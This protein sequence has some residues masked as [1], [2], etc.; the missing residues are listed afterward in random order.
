MVDLRSSEVAP[1]YRQKLRAVEELLEHPPEPDRVRDR[2]GSNAT[3]LG[4]VAT[5][6]YCFLA[7]PRSFEDALIFS[8]NLGGDTDSVAAMTGAI[9]GA[10]HGARAIPPRW[11]SALEEG[12]TGAGY[13]EGLADRLLER[14]L[15]M[16]APRRKE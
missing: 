4:S 9:A 8:V 16:R 2:L 12:E 10:L 13:V 15:A 7:H 3:A 11:R 6:V 5:A 1:E 14:H